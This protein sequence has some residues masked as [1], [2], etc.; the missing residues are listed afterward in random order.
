[1]QHRARCPS[2]KKSIQCRNL[3][4]SSSLCAVRSGPRAAV[5]CYLAQARRPHG[6]TLLSERRRRPAAARQRGMRAGS[7]RE[8]RCRLP[9]GWVIAAGSFSRMDGGTGTKGGPSH[10]QC[11]P[12]AGR[13]L[14]VFL[15]VSL[16]RRP[17]G[18]QGI[19]VC[20]F[21]AHDERRRR[22]DALVEKCA[23]GV[24]QRGGTNKTAHR[25]HARATAREQ[26]PGRSLLVLAA[27]RPGR[28]AVPGTVKRS[29][30]RLRCCTSD[31][32]RQRR[33]ARCSSVGS[34]FG[35]SG[36]WCGDAFGKAT[37]DPNRK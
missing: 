37:R 10:G 14:V 35:Y 20:P 27:L 1:M 36:P 26:G 17:Y 21:V 6:S 28:R 30:D 3:A 2:A 33:L 16:P 8:P 13:P 24:E 31:S 23:R 25:L 5:R 12:K 15:T 32:V 29:V 34:L 18:A 7:V 19:V 9:V 22:I 11:G 4:M